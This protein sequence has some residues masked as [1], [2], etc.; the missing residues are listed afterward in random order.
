MSLT[1]EFEKWWKASGWEPHE[2]KPI[3][4]EAWLAAIATERSE[5]AEQSARLQAMGMSA[6]SASDYVEFVSHRQHCAIRHGLDACTC[7]F[8]A[9]K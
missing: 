5:R 6:G 3:A 1:D 2:A 8:G 7:D 9:T 4:R